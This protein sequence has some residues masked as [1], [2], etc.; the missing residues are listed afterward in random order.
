[1]VIMQIIPDLGTGGAEIMC[2]SLS[3]TL[4]Q[5]GHRV[6]VVSLYD[7]E[8][9]NT[10]ELEEK[11]IP[12]IF[13]NKKRGLDIGCIFRLRKLIKSYSPDVLHTHLYALKYALFASFGTKKKIIHTIH[14]I[15]SKEAEGTNKWINSIAYKLK[16]AK[17]I[18]ISKKIQET[19][20]QEYSITKD[21]TP[22]IYNGI[23]LSKFTPVNSY[24]IH[25]P[26]QIVHVGRFQYQKNHE[27]I[28]DAVNYLIDKNFIITCIGDGEK[29]DE[30]VTKI[31]ERKVNAFFALVG[32]SNHVEEYLQNS[33]IFILPSRWEG[34]PISILEAM[35]TGLPIIASDVGGVSDII[36]HEE[37]GILINPNPIE[38]ANALTKLI[39]DEELRTR[40]GR[41][42]L[43][44][45][46]KYSIEA[47]T[48]KYEYEYRSI[49]PVNY[50]SIGYRNS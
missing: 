24:A 20:I 3:I 17:P 7:K 42:A 5:K 21:D 39:N 26:V 9:S 33:D 27:C 36:K 16:I 45:S 30:I 2:K 43:K 18:S 4:S 10:K 32:L 50:Q 35:A 41:Q 1:M 8:T 23:D 44:D 31:E 28:V 40:I 49:L 47:M 25:C 19:V 38:L 37:N 48:E 6:I 13:L 22:I 12:V 34:L 46:G 14:N 29:R 15:A 11:S